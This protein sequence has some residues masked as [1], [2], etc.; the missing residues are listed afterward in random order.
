M[1]P[2]GRRHFQMC[3]LKWN[4]CI[5]NVRINN[6]PALVQIMAWCWPGDKPLSEAM[7]ITLLTHIYFTRPQRVNANHQIVCGS[8]MTPHYQ[9]SSRLQCNRL[10]RSSPLSFVCYGLIFACVW[11]LSYAHLEAITAIIWDSASGVSFR[12]YILPLKNL[13]HLDIL[14]QGTQGSASI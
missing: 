10:N 13:R 5:P 11:S 8:H 3:F 1:P 4:A 6:I 9:G 12:S 7:M 2:F 14:W